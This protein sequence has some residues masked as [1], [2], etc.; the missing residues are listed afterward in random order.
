[1]EVF[2]DRNIVQNGCQQNS[3]RIRFDMFDC[4]ASR[5]LIDVG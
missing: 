3:A 5:I 2:T 4:Q 1:M